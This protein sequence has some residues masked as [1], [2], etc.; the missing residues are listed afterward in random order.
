MTPKRK[1]KSLFKS[2]WLEK[3]KLSQDG[4]EWLSNKNAHPNPKVFLV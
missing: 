1:S 2:A 4:K 3:Y